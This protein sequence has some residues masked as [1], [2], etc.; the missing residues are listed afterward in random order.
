MGAFGYCHYLES[1]GGVAPG[2]IVSAGNTDDPCPD[3]GNF[4]VA[5]AHSPPPPPPPPPVSGLISRKA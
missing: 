3:H 2:Q 1:G 4:N 5:I